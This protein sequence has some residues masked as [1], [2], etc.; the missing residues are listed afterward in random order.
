MVMNTPLRHEPRHAAKRGFTLVELS[1]VL[2]I[3]GLIIAGVLKG[4]ELLENTRMKASLSQVEA[5]RAAASTFIERYQALPGDYSEGNNLATNVGADW[6]A[7]C[8]GSTDAKCDGDGVIEGT[9]I[10]DETL[11]FWQHLSAANMIK[12]VQVDNV[13][14][15]KVGIGLPAADVGGGYTVDFE[16]NTAKTTHWITL[17]DGGATPVGVVDS[18]MAREM[19]AKVDDGRPQSGSVRTSTAGCTVGALSASAVLASDTYLVATIQS[20][21]AMV[22]EL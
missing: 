15:T 9:G 6:G 11:I 17:G 14:S 16:E 19:D 10:A 7:L 22:F 12:G 3:V 18:Q 20:Q 21:C 8:D 2:V 5:I 13:P 1:I 4:Q